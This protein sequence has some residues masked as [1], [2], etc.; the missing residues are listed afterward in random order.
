MQCGVHIP[1]DGTKMDSA[2]KVQQ[3]QNRIQEPKHW[4][5]QLHEIL[6]ARKQEVEGGMLAFLEA[7]SITLARNREILFAR[8]GTVFLID[9]AFDKSVL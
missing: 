2:T 9:R 1:A 5:P 3:L 6:L 8:C 4:H 7:A